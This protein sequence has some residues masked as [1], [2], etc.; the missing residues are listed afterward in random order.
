MTTNRTIDPT[1]INHLK[2]MKTAAQRIRLLIFLIPPIF[3]ASCGNGESETDATGVF[4][5]TEIIV[6][7]EATGKILSFEINEGDPVEKEQVLGLVDSTQ[8][9]LKKLQ[10][11]ANKVAVASNRPD[12]RTQI[13]AT[14]QEIGKQEREKQRIERLLAGDVATQKQLDDIESALRVLKAKLRS[15]KSSLSN[16]ANSI[17]AQGTTIEIQIEQLRDQID[18]CIIRSPIDGTVLVKY[19]EP[20]EVTAMGKPL[21]KVADLDRM[22]LK[23][24]VTGSQ[25]A[26]IRVGQEVQ[27]LAEVGRSESKA[28][29]G[30]ISW[31][32]GKSEFT[33]KTI[34]TQDERANL[35]YAVKIAVPNDGLLKIGMYGGFKI[36]TQ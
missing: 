28:Y 29:P 18:K 35:V 4:E 8:L 34:Q 26:K 20:G 32:S 15:Q 17:D 9:H 25:L 16:S 21:F 12:I 5:A 23:A 2:I 7:S 33:P 22:T 19:A 36:K 27:V 1:T 14:E 24:Y 13:E 10:F 11:E 3:L 31:I 30:K 6:S